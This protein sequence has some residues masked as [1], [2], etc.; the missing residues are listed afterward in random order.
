MMTRRALLVGMLALAGTV[1]ARPAL[2]ADAPS[3][4]VP[5]QPPP[6]QADAGADID[7]RDSWM[8][9]LQ[10]DRRIATGYFTIENRG[11]D[12][13]LLNGVTAPACH[14]LY[15][16]HTEQESTG[17]TAALF[18]H[19]ALP[20]QTVLVFPPGGYHLICSGYDDSVQPGRRIPVTFHFLG[21]TTRT[22]PFDIR[23][24]PDQTDATP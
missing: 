24:N 20:A 3:P 12:A 8:Q 10:P 2:A 9:I 22:V 17:E 5:G 4:A 15:A 7:I 16:H 23:P 11:K 6:G 1:G 13:H 14:A 19:L 18:D 21:G